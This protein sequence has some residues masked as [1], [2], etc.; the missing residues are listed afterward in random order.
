MTTLHPWRVAHD[1][2]SSYS[3]HRKQRRFSR[4]YATADPDTPNAA[5]CNVG[6][7]LAGWAVPAEAAEELITH[8]R[9]MVAESVEAYGGDRVAVAAV[10]AEGRVSVH[11]AALFCQLHPADAIDPATSV[12]LLGFTAAPEGEAGPSA[13]CLCVDLALL[14]ADWASRRLFLTVRHSTPQGRR[15]AL[16][17]RPGD[18]P[19]ARPPLPRRGTPGPGD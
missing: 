12:S 9:D 2:T 7:I 19:S 8:T 6:V 10:L 11:V 17:R 3:S 13:R 1:G 18:A 5:A 4:H 14:G 15:P 16:T